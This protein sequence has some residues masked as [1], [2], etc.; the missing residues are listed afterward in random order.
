MCSASGLELTPTS[1]F[2]SLLQMCIISGTHF[3]ACTLRHWQIWCWTFEIPIPLKLCI[4]PEWGQPSKKIV[5]LTTVAATIQSMKSF[6][7][8]EIRKALSNGDASNRRSTTAAST[9]T[10]PNRVQLKCKKRMN[11]RCLITRWYAAMFLIPSNSILIQA[12]N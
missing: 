3:L 1:L 5:Y 9:S 10:W 4:F 11:K 7:V 12:K 2:S 6:D 8:G